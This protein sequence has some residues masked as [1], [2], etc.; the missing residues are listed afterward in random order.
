ME[1]RDGE[2]RHM[3]GCYRRRE[4][5]EGK[6]GQGI[7]EIVSV[8]RKSKEHEGKQKISQG[9]NENSRISQANLDKSKGHKKA[10]K[11]K[12]N[13]TNMKTQKRTKENKIV[14]RKKT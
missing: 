6:R 11:R 13:E 7:I 2:R 9:K 12:R 3:G 5:R 8:E 4:V 10:K 1:G 14:Y